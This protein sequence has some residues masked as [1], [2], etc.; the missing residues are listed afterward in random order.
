[1]PHVCLSIVAATFLSNVKPWR[2][3]RN[4]CVISAA[5]ELFK[6]QKTVLA[7]ENVMTRHGQ[8]PAVI[9]QDGVCMSSHVCKQLS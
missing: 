2:V 9:A 3:C 7:L 4:S 5:I 8:L 6:R 1:M